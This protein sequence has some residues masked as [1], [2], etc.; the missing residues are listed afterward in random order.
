MAVESTTDGENIDH[1]RT[2]PGCPECEALMAFY[3]TCDSCHEWGHKS[4]MTAVLGL[5]TGQ[6][7]ALCLQCCLQ[8]EGVRQCLS[9]WLTPR[10]TR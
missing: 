7:R 4:T 2:C 10:S 9:T 5:A 3:A 1:L 6:M 8:E